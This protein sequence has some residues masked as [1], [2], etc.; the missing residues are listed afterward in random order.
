M[1][2]LLHASLPA[3]LRGGL[4]TNL[5]LLL[6]QRLQLEAGEDIEMCCRI[7]SLMSGLSFF[8]VF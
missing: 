1:L 5:D 2:P 7:R 6:G 8:G 3:L 4:A